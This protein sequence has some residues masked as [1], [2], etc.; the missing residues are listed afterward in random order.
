M[1]DRQA[2]PVSEA[3]L[4]MLTDLAAI[5]V[6]ELE[7]RRAA[8]RE[9]E[10]EQRLREQADQL[11]TA[12]QSS[13]LPPCLPVIPN[14][15]IAALFRPAGG[16]EVGGDFYDVFPVN[17]RTWGV[18]IGDVC[19]K[20]PLAAGLSALAH[21]SLRG[22]AVHGDSPAETLRRVNQAMLAGTTDDDSFCTL[23]FALVDA[24]SGGLHV[25]VAVGGHPLPTLLRRDGAV[26]AVGRP[27]SMV[28]SLPDA[29]FHDE[30]VLV[31][32]GDTLLLV[33]DGL[34]EIHTDH[35]VAGRAEFERRLSECAGL[36]PSAVVDCLAAAINPNH[37]DD[38]AILALRAV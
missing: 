36:S 14:V 17:P 2:R 10:L 32:P 37:D 12:L 29:E 15:E 21:Y 16:A 7:L 6:D 5:V 24:V 38:A 35:G 33:T 3:D 34:L 30:E 25:R 22:A 8:R 4:S 1:I 11:A 26:T 18:V 27:G 23:V 9:V 31:E 20:G 28:G 13:L 19:G